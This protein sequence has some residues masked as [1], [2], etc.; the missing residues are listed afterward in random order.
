MKNPWDIIPGTRSGDLYSNPTCP[1]NDEYIRRCEVNFGMSPEGAR[2][3]YETMQRVP[4]G[5]LFHGKIR[6]MDLPDYG[7]ITGCKI[8][9]GEVY[10]LDGAPLPGY[11]LLVKPYES[12]ARG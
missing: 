8:L 1:F 7:K 4:L 10:D 9:E 2:Q 6:P 3:H 12:G 5:Y 11:V